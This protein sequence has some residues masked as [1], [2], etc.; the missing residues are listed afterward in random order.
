MNAV[1]LPHV[2]M[3]AL[4]LT[5]GIVAVVAY[6]QAGASVPAAGAVV[7]TDDALLAVACGNT[8]ETTGE[9]EARPICRV[10]NGHLILDFARYET[11]VPGQPGEYEL[12][13]VGAE[14]A[15]RGYTN[16][17][18]VYVTYLPPGGGEEDKKTVYKLLNRS[19]LSESRQHKVKV[20]GHWFDE[21]EPNCLWIQ[22]RQYHRGRNDPQGAAKVCLP[23]LPGGEDQTIY[24][25]QPGSEYE[26]KDLFTV[27][28][29]SNGDYTI[30]MTIAGDLENP[31]L[32][33]SLSAGSVEFYPS[34]D[35]VT[36]APGDSIDVTVSFEVDEDWPDGTATI[37]GRIEVHSEVIEGP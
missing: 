25:F 4:M 15:P 7:A 29:N 20:L 17:W 33:V 16:H 10:D 2:L 22:W 21:N 34:G 3:L 8:A 26:L 31:H 9:S 12:D 35:S 24:G 11:V 18:Y 19:D 1:R 14:Y 36:L 13:G 27:T 30:T 37:N 23:P 28:N 6:S 5:T 32:D